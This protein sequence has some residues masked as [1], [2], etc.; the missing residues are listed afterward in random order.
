MEQ[1]IRRWLDAL[2]GDKPLTRRRIISAVGLRLP[3]EI[4]TISRRP[5]LAGIERVAILVAAALE[6][7]NRVSLVSVPPVRMAFSA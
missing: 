4:A 2:F 1:V 7:Q 6:M 3:N 5:D